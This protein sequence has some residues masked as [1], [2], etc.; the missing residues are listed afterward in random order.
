MS[1]RIVT[2][3][4][5]FLVTGDG[6]Y[7]VWQA[8]AEPPVVSPADSLVGRRSFSALGRWRWM[9]NYRRF[10]AVGILP[11]A[12]AGQ[13]VT[14]QLRRAT[15]AAG[16]NAADL[17]SPTTTISDD[18]AVDVLAVAEAS[19]DDLG[20][21]AAGVPYTHVTAVVSAAGSPA[22]SEPAYGILFRSE[23]RYAS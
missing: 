10:G 14:V 15:D 6:F 3:L 22:P 17:G 8:G 12:D 11:N 1:A 7:I 19:A 5:D 20:A 13:G 2:E 21:F 9:G 23:G 4:G 16:S 18:D